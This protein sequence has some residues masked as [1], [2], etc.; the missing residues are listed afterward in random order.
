M[1]HRSGISP[2]LLIPVAL[3]VIIAV[4]AGIAIHHAR[5]RQARLRLVVPTPTLPNPNAFDVF[6]QAGEALV[7]TEAIGQ[8]SRRGSSPALM[9]R[10]VA[11]NPRAL[12]LLRRGFGYRYLHPPVRSFSTLFPHLAKWRSLARL[13]VEDSQ[14]RAARGDWGGAADSA[15]TAMQFGAIVPHGAPFIGTLVG[16]AIQAIGQGRLWTDVDH[17]SAAQAKVGV[18]RLQTVCSL[19]VSTSEALQEELWCSYA[20]LQTSFLND[21]SPLPT[22]V[23]GLKFRVPTSRAM[24]QAMIDVYTEAALRDIENARLPYARQKLLPIPGGPLALIAKILLPVEREVRLKITDNHVQNLLLMTTLALRAYHGEHR[25]YPASLQELAPR[26]LPALPEDPFAPDGQLR[27]RN[28]GLDYLLYSVGPDGKDDAGAPLVDP[29]EPGTPVVVPDE[30]S[31]GDL[32][33]GARRYRE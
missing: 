33:A 32:L 21:G 12:A 29:A 5:V 4:G 31:T 16:I 2:F 30:D 22:E 11:E 26:Y 28:R 20:G 13:L 23:T 1:R 9:A 8:A 17:L 14:L 6:V 24:R 27:Y 3:V 18:Q 15:L 19:E 25:G 7:E 10:V